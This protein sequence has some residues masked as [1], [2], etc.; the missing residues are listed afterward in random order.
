MEVVFLSN[1]IWIKYRQTVTF[2]K[3]KIKLI[4]FYK[5]FSKL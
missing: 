5:I 1:T 4:R 2:F 3:M